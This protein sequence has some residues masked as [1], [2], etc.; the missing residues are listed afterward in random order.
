MSRPSFVVRQEP[1]P[2]KAG[3]T[4][5]SDPSVLAFGK[6]GAPRVLILLAGKY[7]AELKEQIAAG[8][9]PELDYFRLHGVLH[10]DVLDATEVQ[11]STHPL[12]RWARRR[13]NDAAVAVAAFLRRKEYDVIFSYSDS[14]S[15]PLAILFTTTLRRPVH[16]VTAHS[17]ASKR[18]GQLL[19]FLYRWIDVIL[20]YS[21]TVYDQCREVIGVPEERLRLDKYL[22]DQR[23]YHPL[24]LPQK[25]MICSV[26]L[27]K[28]DYPTLIEAV[29]GLDVEARLTAYSPW[30]PDRDETK[31]KPLP[32]NVNVQKYD[33]CALRQLYAESQFLVLSLYENDY[34]AGITAMYEAMAMGRTVVVSETRGLKGMIEHGVHGLFVPPGDAKALRA[35]IQELLNDPEKAQQMGRNARKLIEDG[36]NLDDWVQRVA[37][38]VWEASQSVNKG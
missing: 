23:F 13:G 18:R 4:L 26:G 21:Q 35:A 33:F 7:N 11:T 14:I 24:D 34:A 27:E 30:S 31:A 15:L 22:I 1:P 9:H 8:T 20:V 19:R 10:A 12:V 3:L 6:P 37:K 36:V 29:T 16:V 28:R 17:I 32:P 25:R 5:L 2:E 38:V